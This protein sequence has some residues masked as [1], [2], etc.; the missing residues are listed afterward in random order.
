M[1]QTF[2]P[3]DRVNVLYQDG[4]KKAAII[5]DRLPD[6]CGSGQDR[7]LLQPAV[8]EVCECVLEHAQK[9]N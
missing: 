4:T 7:Y 5:V 6:L 1:N 2:K 3:G 8:I 9:V